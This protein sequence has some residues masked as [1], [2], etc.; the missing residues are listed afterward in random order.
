MHQKKRERPQRKAGMDFLATT[1]DELVLERKRTSHGS[2]WDSV[3]G[4]SERERRKSDSKKGA[5]ESGASDCVSTQ[6]E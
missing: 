5:G 3:A 6:G 2:T 4:E 1:L